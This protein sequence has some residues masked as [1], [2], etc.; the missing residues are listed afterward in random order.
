MRTMYFGPLYRWYDETTPFKAGFNLQQLRMRYSES[1][2]PFCLGLNSLDFVRRFGKTN[3]EF[4]ALQTNGKRFIEGE[5]PGF[6][7]QLCFSSGVREQIFRDAKRYFQGAK[8]QEVTG[9]HYWSESLAFGKNF[10]VMPQ[11]WMYWCNCEKCRK[12]APGGRD[13]VYSNPKYRQAVSDFMWRFTSEIAERLAKEG[14]DCVINQMAYSPYDNV[15]NGKIAPNVQVQVAVN[16]LGGDGVQDK[17]DIQKMKVWAEKMGHPVMLWTYA[18][19]KHMRKNIPGIPPMMPRHLGRFIDRCAPYFDGGFFEA[20]TDYY[21]FSYLNFYL[22]AQKLWDS[23]VDTEKLLDEHYRLMFGKGAPMMKQIYETLEENWTKK[24]LGTVEM[25][26]IGPVT[27]VPDARTIWTKIYSPAQMQKFHQLADA[28]KRAAASDKGAVERIEFIRKHLLGPIDDA[29]RVW[30]NAQNA[31]D[32]WRLPL[33]KKGYLRTL[34]GEANEV[35]TSFEVRKNG[36]DVIF[37]FECQEPAMKNMKVKVGKFDDPNTWADSAIELFLNPSGDR[38]NYYQIII[39]AAGFPTVYKHAPGAKAVIIPATMVKTVAWKKDDRW[40]LSVTLPA[41]FTGLDKRK[42]IPVNVGRHRALTSG[43]VKFPYY[44]WNPIRKPEKGFHDPAIWG[45]VT[46]EKSSGNLIKNGDFS[47]KA[48]EWHLWSRG[49]AQSGCT[50]TFD[51][52]LFIAG[53]ESLHFKSSGK[54]MNAVQVIKGLKPTTRYRLSYFVRT[55]DL[56]GKYGAGAYISLGKNYGLAFPPRRLTGTRDWSREVHTFTT[57][58]VIDA[59][60]SIGL[61]IWEAA[62]DVWFDCVRLE[63]IKSVK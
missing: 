44:H 24:I 28:A 52:S 55:Q 17:N 62:G 1:A 2:Y 5:R 16:G 53:G 11:D 12:I 51:K 46:T 57:P 18:Q 48:K 27:R 58:A 34:S 45:V 59:K 25:T 42:E 6:K 13:E 33:Y 15:P 3:P 39:N 10:C 31:L 41:S 35:A 40:A 63:E 23:S 49:G 7:G 50:H 56:K 8:P 29:L 47:E 60:L 22:T 21:I 61:W 37:C 9:K 26:S 54:S 38:K 36:N 43:S 20:E 30:Q 4:F 14:F 32:F 19:G